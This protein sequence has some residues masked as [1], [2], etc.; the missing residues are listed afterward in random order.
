MNDASDVRYCWVVCDNKRNGFS[1]SC[2]CVPKRVR[3]ENVRGPLY[4][5]VLRKFL[6]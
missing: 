4:I 5:W 2:H 6:S 1:S 3:P